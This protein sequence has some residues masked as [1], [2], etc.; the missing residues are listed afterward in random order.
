MEMIIPAEIASS[1]VDNEPYKIYVVDDIVYAN[2][3][4]SWFRYYDP[5][6]TKSFGGND[7]GMLV[8]KTNI[9]NLSN[10]IIRGVEECD[11]E[12]C[13]KIE[14]SPAT[15]LEQ[16]I[17]RPDISFK[18]QILSFLASDV[19]MTFNETIWVSTDNYLL[20]K[21]IIEINIYMPKENKTYEAYTRLYSIT[22]YYDFNKQLVPPGEIILPKDAENGKWM[23]AP[24]SATMFS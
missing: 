11:G 2:F 15:S 24:E 5:D 9:I 17:K 22:R 3:N 19:R 6:V 13:F 1:S 12:N 8:N 16:L 10:S 20:N 14:I 7:V 18:D 4:K 23:V 21:D